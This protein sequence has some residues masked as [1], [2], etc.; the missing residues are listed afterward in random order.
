MK[1]TKK[2]VNQLAF[3]TPSLMHWHLTKNNREMPWKGVKEVYRIWL[4]EII[5]QQ[6][7]VEQGR[8]YYEKILSAYPTVQHLADA[9]LEAVMKLWEGLGYYS[10][11]R[12]LHITAKQVAYEYG[13]KFPNTYEALLQL[14]GVGPYTAAAIAS[15]AYDLPVAV[16]DGNVFRVLSR[17]LGIEMPID[18]LEGKKYFGAIAQSVLDP[19]HP[20]QYNQAIMD[21]GATVCKPAAPDCAHCPLQ[22]KCDAYNSNRVGVLPVIQK[23]IT[24]KTRWFIFFMMEQKGKC[25]VHKRTGKDIWPNLWEFPKLEVEKEKDFTRILD[26]IRQTGS[27]TR[28]QK[29]IVAKELPSDSILTSILQKKIQQEIRSLVLPAQT[30]RQALTHQNIRAAVVLVS[31]SPN[32][33][34]PAAGV[35]KTANEIKALPF[36]K[37]IRDLM[38]DY[39]PEKCFFKQ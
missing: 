29:K 30:Y 1:F 35:W 38:R 24:K 18:S 11:C 22:K 32:A 3:F 25:L 2:L 34:V 26:A 21:F 12:N 23:K 8:A 5:L 7:R 13:G 27:N 31:Y 14:K 39:P 36:P 19:L 4:S 16:L 10:R 9:P 28:A 15:F 6:T 37:I 33:S 20:A 17:F